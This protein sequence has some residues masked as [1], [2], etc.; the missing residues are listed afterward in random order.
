MDNIQGY[1]RLLSFPILDKQRAP[2]CDGGGDGIGPGLSTVLGHIDQCPPP[3]E[4]HVILQTPYGRPASDAGARDRHKVTIDHEPH[5]GS[6]AGAEDLGGEE[7]LVDPFHRGFEHPRPPV[8]APTHVHV[9]FV[10]LYAVHFAHQL[11]RE[12]GEEVDFSGQQSL[13]CLAPP[14]NLVSAHTGLVPSTPSA[15]HG[16]NVCTVSQVTGRRA[17]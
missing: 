16:V 1:S 2:K 11:A 3:Q 15:D 12:G 17:G 4:R 5:V 9:D 14:V 13:L 6:E 8:E 10:V 7:E